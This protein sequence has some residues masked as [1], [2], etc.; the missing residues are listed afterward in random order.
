MRSVVDVLLSEAIQEAGPQSSGG[1]VVHLGEAATE[2][3]ES[4][5]ADRDGAGVVGA[6][7]QETIRDA[8]RSEEELL[9]RGS[10]AAGS[11]AG[12]AR[13][14]RRRWW[15]WGALTV[16][17]LASLVLVGRARDSGEGPAPRPITAVVGAAAART[18]GAPPLGARP[19]AATPEVSSPAQVPVPSAGSERTD[20]RDRTRVGRISVQVAGHRVFIDGRF[21][22][23]APH[24]FATTCG[25]HSV[26][27]G[28]HGP[29]RRI[30][31]PCGGEAVIA[32]VGGPSPVDVSR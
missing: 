13:W 8:A 18:V 16:A 6:L 28:S 5:G 23:D 3:E 2:R 22:G 31:V 4:L 26:R 17:A 9:R 20:P 32:S 10:L 25:A 19:R 12:G 27:V 29:L 11:L 30:D 15:A 1:V 14:R 7:L 21:A 24:S